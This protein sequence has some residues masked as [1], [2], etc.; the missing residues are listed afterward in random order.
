MNNLRMH[1]KLQ[2]SLAFNEQI[3]RRLGFFRTWFVVGHRRHDFNNMNAVLRENH[4]VVLDQNELEY[5]LDELDKAEKANAQKETQS[6]AKLRYER[7]Q[8]GLRSFSDGCYQIALVEYVEWEK[9]IL[10]LVI[11]VVVAVSGHI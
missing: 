4:F 5:D 1:F 8:L 6:S 7:L 11:D 10:L 9:A 2:H 3:S